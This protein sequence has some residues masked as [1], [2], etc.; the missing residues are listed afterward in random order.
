MVVLGRRS[1]ATAATDFVRAA[2]REAKK[3]TLPEQ[4]NPRCFYNYLPFPIV[5]HTIS[6][7]NTNAPRKC[8]T[9]DVVDTGDR[10]N[11]V[12]EKTLVA[13]LQTSSLFLL[14]NITNRSL[15]CRIFNPFRYIF[16]SFSATES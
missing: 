13:R 5:M 8:I 16:S 15:R 10:I 11:L 3:G 1:D 9:A 6:T 4:M 14:Y 12:T 7:L 2:L